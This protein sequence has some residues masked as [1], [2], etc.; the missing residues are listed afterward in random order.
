MFTNGERRKHIGA[1][2]IDST[3]QKLF[4]VAVKSKDWSRTAWV[5]PQAIPYANSCVTWS[6]LLG[7]SSLCHRVSVRIKGAKAHS[8]SRFRAVT[9]G[10]SGN[11]F[12]CR[13][14]LNNLVVFICKDRWASTK[15]HTIKIP[16]RWLTAAK[17]RFSVWPWEIHIGIKPMIVLAVNEPAHLTHSLSRV[18]HHRFLKS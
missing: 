17:L 9:E 14:A 10:A 8:Q 12:L 16:A 7:L 5:L 13:G 3:I 2:R 15:L 6:Q 1:H 11:S 18:R 4:S